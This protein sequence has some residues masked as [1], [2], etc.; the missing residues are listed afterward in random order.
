MSTAVTPIASTNAPAA[1]ASQKPRAAAGRIQSSI[2][3]NVFDCAASCAAS[4]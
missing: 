3:K 1:D 4:E 2:L